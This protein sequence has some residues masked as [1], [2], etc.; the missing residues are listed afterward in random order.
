MINLVRYLSE[1]NVVLTNSDPDV[2]EW[3][4]IR[5]PDEFERTARYVGYLRSVVSDLRDFE[6][7]VVLSQHEP[8]LA[9]TVAA[10]MTDTIHVYFVHDYSMLY[11]ER[12]AGSVL[13]SRMANFML[14]FPNQYLSQYIFEDVDLI[15]ANSDFMREYLEEEL[16]I[17]VDVV[18]PFIDPQE[19]EPFSTG[20]YITHINPN[21]YKGIDVTLDIARELPGEEFLVVGSEPIDDD[22]RAE[23]DRLPNVHYEG[24]VDDITTVYQRSK[25]VLVP[26]RWR[27]PF[28]IV[29]IEAGYNGVPALTSGAGGLTE[30]TYR[31]EFLVESND[32]EEYVERIETILSDYERYQRL[33]ADVPDEYRIESQ[34]D[35]LNNL[36]SVNF[37]LELATPAIANSTTEK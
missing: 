14:S 15:V 17:S 34:V 20:N 28:G 5:L 16:E 6:P 22:I 9:G 11:E 10:R 32:P 8:A 25:L 35:V 4:D 33:A 27:E 2:I 24:F 3:I 37:D 36:L 7:D 12:Y 1:R 13:P 23:M 26:S 18:Y 21:V 19:F 30:S 31:E 29:P